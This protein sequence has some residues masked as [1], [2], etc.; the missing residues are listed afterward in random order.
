MIRVGR[1]RS[2]H[3]CRGGGGRHPV[4][5]G[6]GGG[7]SPSLTQPSSMA[8]PRARAIGLLSCSGL[9]AS[10]DRHVFTLALVQIQRDSGSPTRKPPSLARS[11]PSGRSEASRCSSDPTTGEIVVFAV[12][13]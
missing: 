4:T 1:V 10:Y 12:I 9:F 6:A 8:A 7:A 2:L 5:A 13:A 3:P 11:S